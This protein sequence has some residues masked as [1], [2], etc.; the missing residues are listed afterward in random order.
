MYFTHVLPVTH[1]KQAARDDR[2][3]GTYLLTFESKHLLI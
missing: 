1:D 3:P 2:S